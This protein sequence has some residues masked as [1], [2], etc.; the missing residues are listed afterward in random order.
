MQPTEHDALAQSKVAR[1]YTCTYESCQKSFSCRS[2]L[3]RHVR[4][5]TNERPFKCDYLACGKCF[6]QRSAL[7][8]HMRTHT[9]ERPHVCEICGRAFS[10]PSSLARHRRVHT[11]KRPYHC[12]F[13]G[14]DKTF[15]RKTTLVKHH[16][17]HADDELLLNSPDGSSK[18][19]PT[20]DSI[21]TSSS[22]ITPMSSNYSFAAYASPTDQVYSA[23]P[24]S[25]YFNIPAIPAHDSQFPWSATSSSFP[26]SPGFQHM[27]TN[28]T[29]PS[30][31]PPSDFAVVAPSPSYGRFPRESIFNNSSSAHSS[32]PLTLSSMSFPMRHGYGCQ[33]GPVSEVSTTPLHLPPVKLEP[34]S[35]GS[36]HQASYAL[37]MS[38]YMSGP[39][40]RDF[41]ENTLSVMNSNHHLNENGRHPNTLDPHDQSMMASSLNCDSS[42]QISPAPLSRIDRSEPQSLKLNGIGSY[43]NSRNTW[44]Q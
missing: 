12:P 33:T 19:S 36:H 26:T 27:A 24:S 21:S 29:W 13:V 8:V 17:S 32:H 15:C 14:C 40:S 23:P 18:S 3:V 42:A 2:D 35:S 9:G 7:T 28:S 4:I 37:P 10:D 1:P 31:A 25:Q 22:T 44:H 34:T 41:A 16:K 11:G 20:A 43:W 39:N 30:R 6:I 38:S 5:H